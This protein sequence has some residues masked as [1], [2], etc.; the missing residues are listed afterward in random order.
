LTFTISSKVADLPMGAAVQV[1]AVVSH[2]DGTP[3]QAIEDR[4]GLI[5]EP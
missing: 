5:I 4:H 3:P 2:G 1:E